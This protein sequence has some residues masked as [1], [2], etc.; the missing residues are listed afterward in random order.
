MNVTTIA[1]ITIHKADNPTL[2][3]PLTQGIKQFAGVNGKH[4]SLPFRRNTMALKKTL[5]IALACGIIAGILCWFYLNSLEEKYQQATKPVPVV[6]SKGYIPRGTLLKDKLVQIVKTPKEFVQPGALTSI[7]DLVD[8]KGNPIYATTLPILSN[9]Q[10]TKTKL[11]GMYE[12]RGL[13]V[14]IPEGKTAIAI[15]V[16]ELSTF[17]GLIRPGNR[18]NILCT[19]DYEDK[20]KSASIT[21]TLLQNIE[22]IS[23]G[24]KIIGSS[25]KSDDGRKAELPAVIQQEKEPTVMTL[26]LTP[27][28]SSLLT[29]ASQKGTITLVLRSIGDEKIE[30]VSSIGLDDILPGLKGKNFV[31]YSSK[32]KTAPFIQEMQK[33]FKPDN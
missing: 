23:V 17:G 8:E 20:N 26:A 29:F 10:I 19:F 2:F 32:S 21:L 9:E 13:T 31:P 25:D 28:E 7:S 3:Y 16:D 22:V 1:G 11:I 30:E 5:I 14:A 18:V 33:L 15:P 24:K 12:E 27:Q 6:V 4:A